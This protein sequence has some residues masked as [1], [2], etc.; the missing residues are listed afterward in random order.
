MT[1]NEPNCLPLA[2]ALIRGCCF[3][4]A[5][6][7]AASAMAAGAEPAGLA[8]QVTR[9]VHPILVGNEHGPL[10]R[11]AIEA[12]PGRKVH[13]SALRFSLAG[14]DALAD[15]DFLRV[16]STG[17]SQGFSAQSPLGDP[18]PP[19]TDIEV[20]L[21]LDLAEGRNVFWLSCR[22]KDSADLDHRI[23][24]SCTSIA[25][26]VGKVTPR[27]DDASRQRIGVALRRGGD[28]GVH[29]YRIPA[30][31]TSAAGTLLAVYDMRHRS[32]SD[33]QE[34]IDIGLSRS[35]DGGRTWEKPRVIMDMGRFG[36]LPPEQN[37]CSDPG[38]VV[39]RTTGEIFCFAVWMNGKPGK[40][41]WVGDGS[42]PGFDIGKAA[43]F[44]AVRS[45][46]DGRT[47]SQPEN[48]TRSLKREPWWLF[49]PAPQSGLCLADG[50]LVMPVQGRDARG[51]KF[52]T[53]M[54]SHDHG[55]SW[56]VG[57]PVHPGG[58][59][60]QAVELGDGSLML[61]I[62]ND[63]EK[64]RAVYVTGDLGATWQ[65][66]G[67]NR[68]TLI[69]PTCNAGLLRV[70]HEEAGLKKHVLL[71]ANPHSQTARTHQTV[72][73]SFDDGRSWPASHHLLLDEGRGK[74]YPS[75]TRI[76]AGHVGIVYEGSQAQ[77]VFQRLPLAELLDPGRR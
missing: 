5:F 36:G 48:L 51:A 23:R 13:V 75:L 55:G 42:E 25:T 16:F 65:V 2:T 34:D 68:N 72:Q 1:R 17:T 4:A 62:R 38:I 24:A 28:D 27:D 58:S 64:F 59:E 41:Q 15:I 21:D 50:T 63:R 40:H 14:T 73:V 45:R 49:A 70:D 7:P 20:P 37:G 31:T 60:C 3:V 57:A 47:W 76:D 71:F 56:A 54:T 35:V 26:S 6:F 33:L 11:V 8:A 46:D 10:V 52:S 44:M 32:D 69:E 53:I 29:T 74:G 43:Q 39:D 12:G 30:L 18:V 9:P 66:H 77:L 67:T 61:N 19:A 22:L